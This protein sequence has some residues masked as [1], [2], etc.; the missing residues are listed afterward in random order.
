MGL[1]DRSWSLPLV[2]GLFPLGHKIEALRPVQPTVGNV[3][4]VLGIDAH[5]LCEG[6][7]LSSAN[8][9]AERRAACCGTTQGSQAPVVGYDLRSF[10]E[11][12]FPAGRTWLHGNSA[13]RGRVRTKR[14]ANRF[15]MVSRLGQLNCRFPGKTVGAFCLGA[16]HRGVLPDG[17]IPGAEKHLPAFGIALDRGILESLLLLFQGTDGRLLFLPDLHA[18]CQA[19]GPLA[20]IRSDFRGRQLRECFLPL[21]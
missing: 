17:G 18:I 16:R 3:P 19:E 14:T 13:L 6:G 12:S 21:L 2:H 5:A 1:L 9:G 8:R 7:G 15:P 10:P 4:A 20:L 11:K